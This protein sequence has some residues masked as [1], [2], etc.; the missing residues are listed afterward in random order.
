MRTSFGA[1]LSHARLDTG[2][3]VTGANLLR[4]LMTQGK[5]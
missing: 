1:D 4:A 3:Q 2:T 5:E